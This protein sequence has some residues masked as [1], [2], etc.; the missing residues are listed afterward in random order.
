MSAKKVPNPKD[1]LLEMLDSKYRSE[2]EKFR[3]YLPE[4]A[5][6]LDSLN[7]PRRPGRSPFGLTERERRHHQQALARIMEAEGTPSAEQAFKGLEH[8]ATL[9][10]DDGLPEEYNYGTLVKLFRAAVGKSPSSF[11]AQE[12]IAVA[13]DCSPADAVAKVSL[14]KGVSLDLDRGMRLVSITVLPSKVRQRRKLLAFVGI[15]QDAKSDVALRH[16]EYLAEQDPHAS[17]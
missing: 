17:S 1:E 12:T 14:I 4:V 11:R 8:C 5:Q 6:A 7:P 13:A 10:Q 16:D 15:G 3:S 2:P 9:I